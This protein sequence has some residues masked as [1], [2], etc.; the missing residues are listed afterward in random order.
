VLDGVGTVATGT[1]HAGRVRIGDELAI[2]PAARA[3]A[4]RVRGLHVHDRRGEQAVAGQRCALALA[5]ASRDEI[6]RGP[7]L[8]APEV[9]LATDRID[10]QLTVWREEP[11]ALRSGAPVHVHLGAAD[12]LGTLALLDGDALA[13][14]ASGRAQLVLREPLGAWHGDRVVL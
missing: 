4:V 1:I 12:R 8:A 5:G 6:E 3:R 14:G 9:A 11:R 13:P 7:W 2:A 10:V